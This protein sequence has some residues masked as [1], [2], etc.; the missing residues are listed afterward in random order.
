[1][2]VDLVY[3]NSLM[4][5]ESEAAMEMLMQNAGQEYI[6]A[7]EG[8]VATKNNGLY[9]AIG[10]WRGEPLTALQAVRMLG[11]KAAYVIAVGACATHGGFSAASPTRQAAS[12][13]KAY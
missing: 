8:A 6:L 4:T 13:F 9:N 12:V 5:A 3:D 10:R 7:V 2:V 11:E 1:M